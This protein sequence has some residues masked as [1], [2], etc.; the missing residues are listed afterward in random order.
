MRLSIEMTTE[1]HQRLKAIAALRGQSMK[2]YI[3]ARVL[4]DNNSAEASEDG[5][6]LRQLEA[7]LASR[8]EQA[9]QGE[10]LARSVREIFA[11]TLGE[12]P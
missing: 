12:S 1:Q 11:E 4:P 6:A 2:D 3:L 9:A 5:E 10:T 7:F 8:I